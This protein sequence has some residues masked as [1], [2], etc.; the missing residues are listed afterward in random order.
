MKGLRLMVNPV[1]ELS[2]LRGVT[3]SFKP[4]P[5]KPGENPLADVKGELLEVVAEIALGDAREISFKLL[6]IPVTYD[7]QKQELI[8]RDQRASLKPVA[9]KIQLR[10]F[11]DRTAVDI[12]GNNGRLY[13]PMGIVVPA[14]NHFLEISAKGG[15][16]QIESLT[17]Y[18]LQ[19]AW[20]IKP[21][22]KIFMKKQIFFWSL[23]SALAGFL[24]GFD[25]VVISGAEQKIQ[26]LWGIKPRVAWVRHWLRFIRNRPGALFGGWPNGLFRAQKNAAV[27][28]R[29]LCHLG[30]GVC[31]RQ[32]SYH[33]HHRP[34]ARRH[35]YRHLH[36]GRAAL[37]F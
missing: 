9:D 29:A 1:K 4:Q 5:L 16:A 33:V 14:D 19:S 18:E 22:P 13:M 21:S 30:R 20:K 15:T 17:V 11:V 6:G 7:V 31:L 24:F 26:A 2:S 23:V 32:W 3:H 37:H 8:C 35:R 10:I 25:T 12:F 27:H 28:R 36:G 34:R